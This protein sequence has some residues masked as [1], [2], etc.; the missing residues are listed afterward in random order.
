ARGGATASSN[1]CHSPH[2]SQSN[3]RSRPSISPHGPRRTVPPQAAYPP[4]VLDLL[5]P[6]W[7]DQIEPALP[8][9]SRPHSISLSPEEAAA[10]T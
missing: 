3:L 1:T 10:V 5:L 9:R 7:S 4:L 6:L 2:I 8:S